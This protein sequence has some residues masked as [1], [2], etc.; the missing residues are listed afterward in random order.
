MMPGGIQRLILPVA[1]SHLKQCI[2]QSEGLLKIKIMA[3][4]DFDW[5]E[6]ETKYLLCTIL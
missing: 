6:Y 3:E 1:K 5:K 2:E 4:S